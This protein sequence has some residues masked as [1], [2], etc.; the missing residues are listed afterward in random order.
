[1]SLSNGT[2]RGLCQQ[3]ETD[4]GVSSTTQKARRDR[5]LKVM[6]AIWQK[7]FNFCYC[8]FYI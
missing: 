7:V 5:N 8:A 2:I 4:S 1:M 6:E 3:A